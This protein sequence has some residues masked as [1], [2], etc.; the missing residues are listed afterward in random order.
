MKTGFY[1]GVN[2]A[3]I[4]ERIRPHVAKLLDAGFKTVQ[5][6]GHEMWV[7]VDFAPN[8]L[9]EL[10]DELI[11]LGYSDFDVSYTLHSSGPHHWEAAKVTFRGE[12]KGDGNPRD[13]ILLKVDPASHPLYFVTLRRRYG[14]PN[15]DSD[16]YFYE[17]HTCPTNWTDEIVAVIAN[18]DEDPHGFAKFVKRIPVPEGM[19]DNGDGADVMWTDLFPE[20]AP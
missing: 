18:G 15:K 17:E 10:R 11:K 3:E 13:L 6:C 20:V 8:R 2:M 1:R 12:L 9:P 4:E 14:A 19:D 16:H 7:M 5:S